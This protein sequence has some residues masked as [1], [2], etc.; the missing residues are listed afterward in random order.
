MMP[1]LLLIIVMLTCC[2][3]SMPGAGEG[4]GYLLRPDFGKVTPGVVVSALGQAF[5]S[6][7][8]GVG[9]LTTYA[10]YFSRETNLV[11][12]AVGV[13]AIDSVV[14]VLAGFI[15]FPAVFSVKGVS[16]DAGPGLVFITLPSVFNSAFGGLPAL[17]YVFSCLFYVLLLLAALTSTI[18]M[19][20]IATAFIREQFGLGRRKAATL[21]TAVCMVLGAA[22]SLSFGPWSGVRVLGMGFFDLFDFL[23][24]KYIMPLGGLAITVFVGWWLNRSIVRDELSVSSLGLSLLLFLIRWVAPVGVGVIFVSQLIY[25]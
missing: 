16:V 10:S 22:C 3:L 9:C 15:I 4:L 11:R 18:S 23:T 7:S 1:L 24:A 13:C 20:E 19:H 2:S 5:F 17:S 8:V 25:S 12:S 14:A 6:L 21:V